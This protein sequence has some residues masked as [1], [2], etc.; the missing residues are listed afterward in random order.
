MLGLDRG[1]I[2]ILDE[3]LNQV[4]R[5]DFN[6]LLLRHVAKAISRRL[7]HS[8]RHLLPLRLGLNLLMQLLVR[9]RHED[10]VG[11]T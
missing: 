2:P 3:L 8:G 10:L 11:I 5:A 4:V 1:I 6:L 9:L 7:V